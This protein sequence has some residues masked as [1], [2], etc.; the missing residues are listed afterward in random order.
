MESINRIRLRLSEK[1]RNPAYFNK[2]FRQRARDEISGRIR[3]LRE[4]REM[5][6][7]QFAIESGMKQSAVSR[8]QDPDYSGWTFKT[9][10]RTAETLGARLIVR[11]E[12][13]EETIAH[14]ERLDAA[15]AAPQ[16]GVCGVTHA[17]HL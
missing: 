3:E 15:E 9:L 10:Q 8:I 17:R 14:Y 12:L 13:K 7:A 16:L 4:L 6:Q 5:T 11:F 2:F 1:L